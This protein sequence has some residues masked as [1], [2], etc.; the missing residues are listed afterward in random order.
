MRDDRQ[1]EAVGIVGDAVL[2]A[3]LNLVADLSL[4][5]LS[6]GAALK[7]YRQDGI[8]ISG[9][10]AIRDLDVRVP[11]RIVRRVCRRWISIAGATGVATSVTGP[12]GL[13]ADVPTLLVNNLLAIGEIAGV[14]GF[15]LADP[16]EHAYAVALLF[17]QRSERR[18]Q[19]HLLDRLQEVARELQDGVSW[20]DIRDEKAGR[21]LRNA[22]RDMAWYLVKRKLA[23]IIPGIG[24]LV[25]GGVNAQFTARTCREARKVY[26]QRF[27]EEEG[28]VGEEVVA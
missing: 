25:A 17:A 2:R 26:R 16:D 6:R 13:A 8:E 4:T 24:V 1:S 27:V 9:I 23:Q 7:R 18:G 28:P 14:Y 10:S 21:W 5:Q 3:I 11:D 19:P 22:A 12:V 20:E 15:D